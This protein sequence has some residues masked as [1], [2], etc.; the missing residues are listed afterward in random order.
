MAA[1]VP[2]GKKLVIILWHDISHRNEVV[3][4]WMARLRAP[5]IL[6]QFALATQVVAFEALIH[7][8]VLGEELRQVCEALVGPKDL[9]ISW[10]RPLQSDTGIFASL[11][12]DGPEAYCPVD[13]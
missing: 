5:Q 3:L 11:H 2:V 8:M 4:V 10:H 13:S 12:Q 1:S 7:T 6:P 9:S